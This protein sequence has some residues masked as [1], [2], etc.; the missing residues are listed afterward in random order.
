M[1]RSKLM[2]LRIIKI[3][4][5]A[6]YSR[7]RQLAR[8]IFYF[9]IYINIAVIFFT[10]YMLYGLTFIEAYFWWLIAYYVV[11]VIFGITIRAYNS[12]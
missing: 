3:F 11:S 6:R 12:M 5:K 7:N 8:V 2:L 1:E 10:F 4:N 9:S